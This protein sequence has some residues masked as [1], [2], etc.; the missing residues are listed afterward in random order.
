MSVLTDPNIPIRPARRARSTITR[1]SFRELTRKYF[2]HETKW[3][4]VIEAVI[5][6]IIAGISAWPIVAA[7]DALNEFLQHT[8]G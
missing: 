4:F 2:A 1:R 6:A 5:F 3:Q 7:V 8:P